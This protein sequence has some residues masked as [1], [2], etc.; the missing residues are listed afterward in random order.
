MRQIREGD[1]HQ[2]EL[3]QQGKR[4][5]EGVV[6]PRG[7]ELPQHD[8]E[9]ADRRCEQQLQRAFAVFFSQQAHGQ[10]GGDEHQKLGQL[11]GDKRRIHRSYGDGKRQI[12]VEGQAG[13]Q[14]ERRRDQIADRRREV[15][16]ISRW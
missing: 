6:R 14:Q 9:I 5:Q 10:Q 8:A 7:Q 15:G 16:A 3:I 1:A 12:L 2:D 4:Q 11:P 13:E